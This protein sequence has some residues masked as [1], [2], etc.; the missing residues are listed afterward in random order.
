[1]FLSIGGK[2]QSLERKSIIVMVLLLNG[3]P[4][5]DILISL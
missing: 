5:S 3:C 1:V 2:A 4:W